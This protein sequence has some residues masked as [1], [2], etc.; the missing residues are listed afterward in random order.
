V[1]QWLRLQAPNAGGLGSVLGKG[2]KSHVLQLKTWSSQ[3]NK[4][5]KKKKC[6]KGTL[7]VIQGAKMPVLPLQ[8]VQVQSMVRSCMLQSQKT[9]EG[10]KKFSKDWTGTLIILSFV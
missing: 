2:I 8:G 7:L 3:I 4:Y 10:K 6:S 5:L 1:V 9:E